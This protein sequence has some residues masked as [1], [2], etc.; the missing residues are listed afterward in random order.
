MNDKMDITNFL[1]EAREGNPDA[2][3]KVY[4]YVYDELRSIAHRQLIYFRTG[5]TLHTTA[6]I[7]EA[8]E[9]LAG[10]EEI[11]WQDRNHFFAVTSRAMRHILVD[12]ARS[13]S[14]IKRGGGGKKIPLDAIQLAVEEDPV[15]LAALDDALQQLSSYNK[16]F[17]QLVELKFFGGLSFEEIANIMDCSERTV[18]RDWQR[19]RTWIYS[20]M[21]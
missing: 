8:Y 3:N 4:R 19:A 18:R 5:E 17:E 1:A 7:H 2:F 11:D 16:Q 9:R 21:Q 10:K 15:D 20:A 6:L 13:Q 14:A 12:Y